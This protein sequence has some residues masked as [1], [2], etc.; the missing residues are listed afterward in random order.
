[1]NFQSNLVKPPGFSAVGWRD[2]STGLQGAALL[3]LRERQA[4]SPH[5][6]LLSV[7]AGAPRPWSR[8]ETG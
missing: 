1:M 2:M 5:R 7:D 6:G 8:G 4:V 3:K